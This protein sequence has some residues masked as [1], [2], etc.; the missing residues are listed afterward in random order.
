MTTEPKFDIVEMR[1]LV[2]SQMVLIMGGRT[3]THYLNEAG[4]CIATGL[5]EGPYHME[6]FNFKYIAEMKEFKKAKDEHR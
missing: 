4:D 1:K 6:F 5:G 3:F 2:K